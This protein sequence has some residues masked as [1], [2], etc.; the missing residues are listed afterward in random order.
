M[1][2]CVG[3][4]SQI[5]SIV[6]ILANSAVAEIC[7][8]VDD[9]Y[10]AL[11]SQMERERVRSATEND[12]LRR[13]LRDMDV[14]VRSYERKM[15]RRVQLEE[16]TA[17]Q[18]RPPEGTDDRQPPVPPLPAASED[19]TSRHTSEQD[20]GK[21][22]PL[23]KQEEVEREDCN[24]DLKV[25]VN[26]RAECGLAA[27]LEPNEET[28]TSDV[29][30]TSVTNI[31]PT[32]THPSSSPTD[33]TMD[34][35]CRPRAKRK[36]AKPLGSSLTGSFGGVL[37]PEAARRELGEVV[38]D[39]ALKPEIPTDDITEEELHP[40]QLSA[41]VASDEPSPDRLN[42]LG[43]DLAW[44][45]E[46]VSHLGAAYAVAQLGLGNTEAGQPSASFPSQGGGDS[47][48]GPPTMLFTGGAHE[49]AAFAASFDMAAATVV[50]APP[51][52]PP[53]PST[54]PSATTTSQR[55]PYRS[56][57]AP[58]KYPVACAMCGHLF[59]SAAALERHQ[60]VHTGERP[61]TCPHCGKGFTQPNN[62]RVHLLIHTGERRY[63]CTLCGKSFISSSHLKRHRTVH[64]QEKPYSCSRCGQSFS[65]MCSVR[66]HRQQSQCGL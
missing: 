46:R 5:A 8:L 31:A 58:S 2:D 33:T 47:L 27:A 20:D 22:Q 65:Q 32:T 29:L 54:A 14:K 24:L 6:E 56:S 50:A 12:A 38:T 25:E 19:K 57:P 40:S 18:L 44:M 4:Q 62:L 64:T 53:P 9:G 55:R 23:V 15:R 30:D 61:Y 63:R 66:R 26:I 35:T 37:A 51:P 45:Q 36:A 41:T 16:I 60:R 28:P 21:V 52:P 1:A 59:P 3:F 42:S 43:L 49:M 11:R 17:A 48:D 13:R 39:G 34:L 7:K 10:A